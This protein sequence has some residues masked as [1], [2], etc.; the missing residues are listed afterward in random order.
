M[1][2]RAWYTGRNWLAPFLRLYVRSR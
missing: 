1:E 2:A